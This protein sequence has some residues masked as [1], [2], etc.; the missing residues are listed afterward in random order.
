MLKFIRPTDNI[1]IHDYHLLP[2]ARMLRDAMPELTIGFFLHIPFPSYEIFRLMP[3]QWQ[4]DLL[5]GMLGA[6]VIGFH[7]IDYAAHFLQ[8]VQMVT[9]L[10]HDRHLIRLKDRIIKVD[11]FPISIDYQ[12]FNSAYDEKSVT[13]L[14]DTLLKGANGQQIIFSVDRLDYTKGVNNR[15]NAYEYFLLK[16]PEYKGKVLFL[17]V[18]VPSRDNILKYA[19]RKKMIDELISGINSRFGNL[20]WQPVIYQYC[21]LSFE[22]MLSYYTGCDLALITPLRDG[23][24]LVAKEFVASRK[25]KKGVLIISEMAG[26]A[27]E[28]TDALT[29]NPNDIEEMAS[30]IR[31]GLEMPLTEQSDR[32]ENMQVRIANYDV[33]AWTEDFFTELE[34]VKKRQQDFKVKFLDDYSRGILLDSY[35]KA[36]KRLI[37]LDYDGTL[38]PFTSNPSSAIPDTHLLELLKNLS[39]DNDVYIVSGRNSDWLEKYFGRHSL[40]LI[41]EHGARIKYHGGHWSNEVLV[42]SEWKE[43]AI[44]LMQTYVRR[45]AHSTIEEKEYSLVWH[46]RNAH[47]EQ[48]KLRAS[49]LYAELSD[50]AYNRHLE[51]M[52][53]NKIVEIRN[54]G[55]DKGAAVRKVLGRKNYDYVL[56]IGD[57]TTDEDMFKILANGKNSFTIKV[58]SDASFAKY[59]LYTPQMV[60]SLL[61]RLAFIPVRD[62]IQ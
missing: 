5:Y 47:P 36:V 58:G 60:I 55:V 2:L 8:S 35:R 1:W 11:V 27:R 31:T 57:D 37:V 42:R 21:S 53:G 34:N 28:L 22:E 15:L 56:A 39:L 4:E 25:D 50:F 30:K 44:R 40:N 38:V 45:C 43:Q 7:T 16:N 51:V 49:E 54:S 20:Q 3:R 61:D 41:A 10:D 14:R 26:V 29:I 13:V 46:Y 6:D 59:N 48:G 12:R 24:N 32:L 19:E 33:T 23:M 18:V 9:G 17:L 52:K 62:A